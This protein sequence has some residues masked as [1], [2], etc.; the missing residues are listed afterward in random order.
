VFYLSES[1]YKQQKKIFLW[2]AEAASPTEPRG[3]V[4]EARGARL[5]VA[6]RRN[7]FS[8]A[9]ADASIF[10]P[11]KVLHPTAHIAAAPPSMG[12]LSGIILASAF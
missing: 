10:L 4:P 6:Q 2:C 3:L 11:G 8:V 5:C 12:T 9:I 7:I 1:K